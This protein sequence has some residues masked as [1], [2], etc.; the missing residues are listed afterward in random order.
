M[1]WINFRITAPT[2]SLFGLPA[3]RSLFLISIKIGLYLIATNT[4]I[5]NDFRLLR[6]IREQLPVQVTLPVRDIKQFQRH[7]RFESR[8]LFS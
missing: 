6:K 4:G 1:I 3:L 7:D 2:I 8:T 5:K